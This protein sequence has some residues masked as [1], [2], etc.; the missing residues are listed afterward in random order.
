MSAAGL[1]PSARLTEPVV[2]EATVLVVDDDEDVRGMLC[3]M[4]DSEG[5]SATEAASGAEVMRALASR[6]PD[7]ILLDVVLDCEEIM[8]CELGRLRIGWATSRQSKRWWQRRLQI[9]LRH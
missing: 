8:R 2:P 6:M 9:G 7:L 4:L 3:R 5:Y 1:G